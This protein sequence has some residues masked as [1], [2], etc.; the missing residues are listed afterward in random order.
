MVA[1]MICPSEFDLPT[2]EGLKPPMENF[3]VLISNVCV[4]INIA[5]IYQFNKHSSTSIEHNSCKIMSG[6]QKESNQRWLSAKTLP[7]E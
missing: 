4:E 1:V 5:L 6:I 7:K 3:Y 2:L